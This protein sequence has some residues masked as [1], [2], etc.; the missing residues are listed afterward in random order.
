M[1]PA[2]RKQIE[3][4]LADKAKLQKDVDDFMAKHGGGN[5]IP[6][7]DAYPLLYNFSKELGENPKD[8]AWSITLNNYGKKVTDTLTKEELSKIY[9]DQ[10]NY[11]LTFLKIGDELK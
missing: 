9:L 1:D 8:D 5:T 3:E 7:K 2:K 4:K 11:A 10:A 6:A